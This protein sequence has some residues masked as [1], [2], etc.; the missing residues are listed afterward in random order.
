[1]KKFIAKIGITPFYSIN[2]K[3]LLDSNT[4]VEKKSGNARYY[5][6]FI[7]KNEK[8]GVWQD[9]SEGKMWVSEDIDPSYPLVYSLTIKDHQPNTMFFKSINK[10][11]HFKVFIE[12]YKLGNVYFE[13]INV[14]NITY[15]ILQMTIR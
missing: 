6:T 8:Y 13:S 9:F 14:K 1:M 2:N 10:Q 7:Y 5:F 4:F 15:E 3:F 11:G 12:N